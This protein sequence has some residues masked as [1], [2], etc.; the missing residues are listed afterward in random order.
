MENVNST[1]IA[2][3]ALSDKPRSLTP[4][5]ILRKSNS[6]KEGASAEIGNQLLDLVTLNFFLE[7]NFFRELIWLILLR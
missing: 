7:N 3:A 5:H 2:N 4:S 1:M 6:V